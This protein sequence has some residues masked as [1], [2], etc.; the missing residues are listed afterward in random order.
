MAR[1]GC[2]LSYKSGPLAN[3]VSAWTIGVI[4]S[5]AEDSLESQG[6]GC[7]FVLLASM[8]AGGVQ[9]H[10]SHALRTHGLELWPHRGEPKLSHPV[11]D[12]GPKCSRAETSALT[13][14][15]IFSLELA[16]VRLGCGAGS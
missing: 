11:H 10:S 5:D 7:P 4:A 1:S 14:S 8:N 6:V 16:R 3:L 15:L 2:K 13:P 12:P 9:A